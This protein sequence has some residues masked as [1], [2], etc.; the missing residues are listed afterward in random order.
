MNANVQ[1]QEKALAARTA[2]EFV[3]PGMV[4]GIGSGTTAAYAVQYLGERVRRGLRIVAVSTSSQTSALAVAQ[5]I[6]LV[7]TAVPEHIDL[8]IDGADEFDSRLR[9]I[10]GGGGDLLHEKIVASASARE[11]II[12][13]HT[14]K[15][16]TLGQAFPLAVEVIKLAWPLV[17]Q[18]MRAIG[19]TPVLRQ[20]KDA[21]VPAPFVTD[22]GNYIID[23][24]L[25]PIAQP[26]QLA[27]T[28]STMPGVVE[29]GLFLDYASE[30]IM[31]T[32]TQ[33]TTFQRKEA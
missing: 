21:A 13:D 29:H 12:C 4:V 20:Q 17:A 2:V 23:W 31:A 32:G 3:Q 18:K 33:V 8:T 24:N 27:L 25:G 28:L 19:G 7:T 30:I 11:I 6:P 14:K 1:E 5:G 9:M 26:E 16:D 15:V 22:E 10:K